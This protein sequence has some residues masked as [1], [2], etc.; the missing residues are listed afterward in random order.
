[1]DRARGLATQVGRRTGRVALILALIAIPAAIGA[2]KSG[3]FTL[4]GSVGL[5][6][7][8]LAGVQLAFNAGWIV[9]VTYPIVG[10]LSPRRA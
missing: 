5:L 10:L 9:T 2:R 6:V 1:M 8:F 7:V 4:A 3:L